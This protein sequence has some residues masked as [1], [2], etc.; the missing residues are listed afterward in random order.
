MIRNNI[1]L[2]L[3][4]FAGLALRLHHVSSGG[5]WSDEEVSVMSATGQY[6]GQPVQELFSL[7]ELRQANHLKEVIRCTNYYDSGNGSLYTTSLHYWLKLTGNTEL[8]ARLLSLIFSMFSVLLVYLCS[9]ELMNDK[10]AALSAAAVMALHPLNIEYAQQ[11]RT[12]ALAVMCALL[13]TYSYLRYVREKSTVHLLLYILC[14]TL[15]LLSHYLSISVLLL[16]GLAFLFIFRRTR[17]AWLAAAWTIIA[18]L[19][20]SW[21]MTLGHEGLQMMAWRNARFAEQTA[22]GAAAGNSFYLPASPVNILTGWFQVWLQVFGNG[23]QNLD[24]RIRQLA[25]SLLIPLLLFTPVLLN[26][27]S[28]TNYRQPVLFGLLALASHTLL[29]TILALQS[30][31][32]ISFQPLYGNFVVPFACMLLGAAMAFNF[33]RSSKVLAGTLTLL[34][35]AVMVVTL[36]S[37]YDH[38]HGKLPEINQH[39]VTADCIQEHFILGDTLKLES[40]Q[41]AQLLSFYFPPEFDLVIRRDSSLGRHS[42]VLQNGTRYSGIM[43]C[44]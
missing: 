27:D 3:I 33:R 19:F 20:V 17:A 8:R 30:G 14:S 31:H 25:I 4:F 18:L 1:I 10:T 32:C 12:Y 16:H 38:L 9:M 5:F 23:L 11:A 24:I 39:Q 44:N 13:S 36:T 42:F 26:K 35:L 22:A 29:M 7:H 28:A 40:T 6:P 37:V 43:T 41:Q 2:L 34:Q 15:M 21:L